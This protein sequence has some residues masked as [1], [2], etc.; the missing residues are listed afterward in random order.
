MD[1]AQIDS[2]LNR[3]AAAPGKFASLLSKLEAADAIASAPEGEW[4][5]AE[6][7]AHLRAANDILE[8][9]IFHVLVRDDPPLIA[10]D[11][12]R[13][14]EVG[15]YDT[16]PVTDSLQV[17]RLRRAELVR[18]YFQ[19]AEGFEEAAVHELSPNPGVTDPLYAVCA[20]KLA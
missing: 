4:S 14:R 17:M 10:Y 1:N 7:L 2:V 20:R 18:L 12:T 6:V 19:F 15:R 16:L 8:P 9:R 11:E 5:P 13:W 3:L